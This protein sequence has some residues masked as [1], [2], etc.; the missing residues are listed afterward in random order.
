MK[1]V[2]SALL[3]A[4]LVI[5]ITLQL[6]GLTI[7][8]VSAQE[9]PHV[10]VEPSNI[11]FYSHEINIGQR[12]NVTIMLAN[13]TDEVEGVQIYMTFDPT[14]INATRWFVPSTDPEYIFYGRTTSTLPSPPNDVGYAQ[15][16]STNARIQVAINLFPTYPSQDY[17]NGTGKIC[18]IEFEVKQLP[19]EGNTL[20][21]YI[22]I[23]HSDTY[24]I[25]AGDFIGDDPGEV[26]KTSALYTLIWSA[27]PVTPNIWLE[28][29]P[30]T[31]EAIKPGRPFNIDIII[32]NV[33]ES[34][35]LIGVQFEVKYDST[36]LEAAE[37]Y[38][39]DFLNNSLWA[40]YGTIQSYYIDNFIGGRAVYGEFILPNE[41][42]EWN[43][44]FPSGNGKVATITFIPL[45]NETVSLNITIEP[46]FG[47][48][49]LSKDG[50][51]LP[52]YPAK[53]CQYQY[54]AT[55]IPEPTI[56]VEPNIYI[57][58]TVGETFEV[59]IT[60]NNLD[61]RWELDYAEFKLGFDEALL[62]MLNVTEG[63][64]LSQFGDTT[65]AYEEGT[66]FVKVNITLA[67]ETEAPNG[68]GVLATLRF[69]VTSRPPATCELQLYDTHLR[70]SEVNE[71]SHNLENGY[72]TMHE[73]ITHE[74]TVDTSK[75]YIITVSNGSISPVK[76]D[77][78]HQLLKFNITGLE[79][80]IG[81]VNITIP[82]NLLWADG[83][84]LVIVGGEEVDAIV[85]A[86]NSTH[87]ML[88]FN[89]PFSTKTVYIVGTGVIPEFSSLTLILIF[90][91]S[92]SLSATAIRFRLKRKR[93]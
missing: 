44:P 25:I 9:P 48:F 91:L 92:A 51:Y 22:N 29:S 64:F 32:Q 43:P 38:P 13:A 4:A 50:E 62:E 41:T 17:G 11:V 35:G 56:S 74:I 46:L 36:Y 39:G 72:Y 30:S 80:E 59:N 89:V 5:A 93:F 55:Y 49:F 21:T 42:G 86:V 67:H 7:K 40:P 20:T 76:L 88:Y 12:F 70:Y 16:N 47:E 3:V 18:L 26:Q 31:Y 73:R 79:G 28:A 37:I 60:L 15:I 77:L 85:T 1:K 81:F 54:T 53:E 14:V 71:F 58:S 24:L 8:T 65:F 57:S 2:K 90:L 23:D 75:F 82:N 69:N 6:L 84:W 19:S 45:L 52:Y 68:S 27:P 87:T 61:E 33:S 10:Y 63:S 34:D 83:N 78:E 66:D